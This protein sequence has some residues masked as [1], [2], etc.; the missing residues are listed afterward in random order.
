MKVAFQTNRGVKAGDRV[1]VIDAGKVVDT[2]RVLGVDQAKLRLQS[3]TGSTTEFG[4]F[5]TL[6]KWKMLFEDEEKGQ[7][8]DPDAFNYDIVPETT[9]V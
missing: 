8:F 1:Q 3:D 2:G 5:Q 7:W 6:G 9:A 4:W